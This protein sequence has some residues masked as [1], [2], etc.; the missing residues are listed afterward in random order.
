MR[1]RSPGNAEGPQNIVVD[2]AIKELSLVEFHSPREGTLC[3]SKRVCDEVVL[4]HWSCYS[5]GMGA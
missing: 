5:T 2:K 1:P 4:D 3:L